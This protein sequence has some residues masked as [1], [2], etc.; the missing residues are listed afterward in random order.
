MDH[1]LETLKNSK[2]I[3]QKQKVLLQV[4]LSKEPSKA[5]YLKEA[6]I[7]DWSTLLNLKNLEI[8]G[9]MTMPPLVSDPELNRPYFRELKSLITLLKEKSSPE[10]AIKL[11]ELSMGTSHDYLVATEEGATMVRLG[12]VLFG[13]RESQ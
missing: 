8:C 6:L 2:I 1:H 11:T 3:A 13:E 9:L 7:K 10:H 4:N 5:G 12:T